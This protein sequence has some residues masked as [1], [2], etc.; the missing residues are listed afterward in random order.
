MRGPYCGRRCCG[1]QVFF[2]APGRRAA[3][4]IVNALIKRRELRALMRRPMLF[5]RCLST[6]CRCRLATIIW[7]IWRR[8]AT[9]PARS[10]AAASGAAGGPAW[11]PRRNGRSPWHRSDRSWRACPRP[12]H[13]DAPGSCSP[14]QPAAPRREA[15][16]DHRLEASRRFDR[17][18]LG[19]QG[20]ETGN[21]R[22]KDLRRPGA[23]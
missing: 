10:C 2:L 18:R 21:H 20:R 7:M 3:P 5:C 4:G 16:R 12:A 17:D 8:L 22:V 15:R 19:R 13:S 6:N 9:R 14:R 1:E 23:G 11:L